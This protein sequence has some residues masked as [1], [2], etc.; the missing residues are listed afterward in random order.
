MY[1]NIL[2]P[3]AYEPGVDAEQELAA[4]RQLL[5]PGGRVTLLHVM[6]PVPM[7]AIDYMPAGYNDRLV[8]ALRADLERQAATVPG[9]QVAI[10]T[11]DP[12]TQIIDHAIRN[13]VDCIVLAT[14]RMDRSLYGSTAARVA[15][16][17]P[18]AIHLLR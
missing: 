15:R 18:C 11:G 4:A 5:T 12:A 6:E 3:V 10:A 2:L 14:H 16:H 17:A 13:G 9:G 7:F 8:A 1:R